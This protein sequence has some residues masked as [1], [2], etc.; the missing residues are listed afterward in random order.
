M[1]KDTIVNRNADIAIA[2]PVYNPGKK[3]KACIR[4]ILK[5][6]YRNFVCVL[7]NDGSSDGS[8]KLCDF[9]A[10]MDRRI[11]VIH[12]EYAGSIEARKVGTYSE[13][14]QNADILLLLTQMILYHV[15]L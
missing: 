9:Y 15:M 5:Q 12:Q 3:L 2:V 11:Y 7:V 4:S 8:D 13:V 14:A 1:K 10:A 6:S